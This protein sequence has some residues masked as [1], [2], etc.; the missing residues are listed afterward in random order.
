MD[1]D[2]MFEAWRAQN[3][4]LP[5]DVN[6]DVLQQ[7]LHDEEARIRREM[8]THRRG[9]WF[10]GIVGTG[11][12]VWAAF[13]IAITIANGWPVVYIV[14][15]AAS[16]ALFAFGAGALWAS[17]GREPK[18][19]FGNTLQEEMRRNLALV[20]YQLSITRRWVLPMLATISILAGTGLFN[21]T[22]MKSQDIPTSR[23]GWS[24]FTMLFVVFIFWG[25]NKGRE[26]RRKAKEKLELRQRRLRELLV[27]L[28]ARE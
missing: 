27:A 18:P 23:G 12:A 26:E 14:T 28:E 21:W 17:R 10:A 8:R 5:Y 7:A 11:M 2:Q 13:W 16:L 20:D 9:I 24:W 25:F 4:A 19:N 1:F 22:V 15:S 3:T 6:R